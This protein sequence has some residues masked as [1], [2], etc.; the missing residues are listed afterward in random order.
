MFCLAVFWQCIT[1]ARVQGG[2]VRDHRL[3]HEAAQPNVAVPQRHAV[4]TESRADEEGVQGTVSA[5]SSDASVRAVPLQKKWASYTATGQSATLAKDS[6][7]HALA[8]YWDA[9]M[10][11]HKSYWAYFKLCSDITPWASSASAHGSCGNATLRPD[12]PLARC[13][14]VRPCYL[15]FLP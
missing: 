1:G 14:A 8:D 6:G 9:N 2:E 7:P 4:Q 3:Q 5:Y 15:C 12:C 10:T 13:L 11:G